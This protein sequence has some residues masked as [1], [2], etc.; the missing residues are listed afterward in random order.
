MLVGLIRG[1]IISLFLVCMSACQGVT[2][3]KNPVRTIP[4]D[5]VPEDRLIPTEYGKAQPGQSEPPLELLD[6][7][8]K[9]SD[10]FRHNPGLDSYAEIVAKL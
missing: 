10:K 7:L 4:E 1:L 5:F 6:E 2:V 9:L 8:D 3:L